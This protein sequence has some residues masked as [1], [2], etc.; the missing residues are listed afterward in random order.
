M[1]SYSGP[2][3]QD[4]RVVEQMQAEPPQVRAAVLAWDDTDAE[5]HLMP[6]ITETSEEQKEMSKLASELNTYSDEMMIKFVVGAE[7]L[8]NFEAYQK[9]LKE[10]GLDRALAIKEQALKRFY[11]RN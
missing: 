10:F 6:L 3:V 1:G 2:F 8:E 4:S 5:K 7:P 11:E 9:Q